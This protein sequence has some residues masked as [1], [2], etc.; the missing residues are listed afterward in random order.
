MKKAMS[1]STSI[2]VRLD[3]ELL[4]EVTKLARLDRRTISDWVRLR[5]Q[6]EVGK[7]TNGKSK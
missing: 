4:A 1:K 3:R 6:D 2:H 7:W 5:V